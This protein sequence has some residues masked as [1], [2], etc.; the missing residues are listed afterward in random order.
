MNKNNA[1]ISCN[2][3]TDDGSI[4]S[5]RSLNM[6]KGLYI[7]KHNHNEECNER[8]K[9]MFSKIRIKIQKT[10]SYVIFIIVSGILLFFLYTP[11]GAIRRELF[12]T[13]GIDMAVS[14]AIEKKDSVKQG[15][16]QYNIYQVMLDEMEEEWGVRY[17]TSY[18]DAVKI[19]NEMY[20]PIN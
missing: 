3:E 17:W 14:A 4:M 10:V 5:E 6:C 18:I 13:R 15:A 1:K 19:E 8:Q 12:F 20:E 16:L 9:A 2:L 7:D 11:Q